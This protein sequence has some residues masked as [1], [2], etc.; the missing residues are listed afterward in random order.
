MT[1]NQVSPYQLHDSAARLDMMAIQDASEFEKLIW[2]N[3]TTSI[4]ASIGIRCNNEVF[5]VN[6]LGARRVPCRI[7][8]MYGKPVVADEQ[9]LPLSATNRTA[10]NPTCQRTSRGAN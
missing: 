5:P 2:N 1:T 8:W 7:Y 6:I 10:M 4:L 9:K 3:P